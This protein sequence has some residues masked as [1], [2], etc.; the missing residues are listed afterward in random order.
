MLTEREEEELEASKRT[1][2][3]IMKLLDEASTLGAE[4]SKEP[5]NHR[6]P[7]PTDLFINLVHMGYILRA[8]LRQLEHAVHNCDVFEQMRW[9][10]QAMASVHK[11]K[12]SLEQTVNVTIELV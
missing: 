2:G 10:R 3:H 5:R 9:N 1:P 6:D 7:W 4:A 8:D 11:V 12:E